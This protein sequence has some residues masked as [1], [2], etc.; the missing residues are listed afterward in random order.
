VDAWI[1][2]LSDR[3]GSV[4]NSDSRF[5]QITA[6]SAGKKAGF[7]PQRV[8]LQPG[9][10]RVMSQPVNLA[11]EPL[12]AGGGLAI[13][14]SPADQPLKPAATWNQQIFAIVP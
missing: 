11:D 13:W 12:Y 4:D 6:F 14:V 10:T 3:T 9:E 2:V 7:V 1:R 5:L 8:T